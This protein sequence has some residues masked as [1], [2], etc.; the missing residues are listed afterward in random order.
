MTEENTQTEDGRQDSSA[1]EQQDQT[2]TG[3][4]TAPDDQ[5]KALQ[6]K[7]EAAEKLAESFKDQLLRKAAEFENYKKRTEAE[8]LNLV[9]NANEGLIGSLIPILD[10]LTRSLKSGKEAREHESFYRGIEL[11]SSKFIKLLE[12]HGLI[13]FDSLGKP[14]DVEFHDA[15]MQMPRADMP[16]HTVVDEIERGYKLFDKVIRHAKVIVSTE[17][18]QSTEVPSNGKPQEG[19]S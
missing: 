6:Q 9:K 10:D 3:T 4:Q 13:P 12:S 2:A 19:S 16:P 5:M 17:L 8:Y 18:E 7:L 1:T 14:F 15:L 11:I